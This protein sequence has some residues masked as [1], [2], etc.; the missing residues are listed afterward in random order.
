GAP[1]KGP[2]GA[3]AGCSWAAVVRPGLAFAG[4]ARAIPAGS[5]CLVE[6]LVGGADEIIDGGKAHCAQG[7]Q[8]DGD[9]DLDRSLASVLVD[10]L[11]I[12]PLDAAA[13]ALGVPG[14]SPLIDGP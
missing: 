5:L 2:L 7:G 1:Q 8:S 10:E 4:S 11:K 3:H 14:C 13:N 9:G 12:G 6:L